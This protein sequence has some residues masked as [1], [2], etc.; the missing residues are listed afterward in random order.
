VTAVSPAQLTVLMEHMYLYVKFVAPVTQSRAR[1][2][3]GQ[4]APVTQS[5]VRLSP[6]QNNTLF[7]LQVTKVPI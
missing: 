3:P 2:S 1:L 4:K 7:K 5:R 6:G